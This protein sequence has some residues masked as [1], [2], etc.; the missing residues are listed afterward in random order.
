MSKKGITQEVVE[1]LTTA[2]GREF[3]LYDEDIINS[4]ARSTLFLNTRPIAVVF[5]KE[6]REVVDVVRIANKYSLAIHPIS[7]GKNWGYSDA[8][9]YEEASL[10]IDLHRMDSIIEVNTDLCYAVVEPGVTQKKLFNYLRDHNIPLWMDATGAD[11]DTSII[12]NISER[13]FGYS[14]YG[15]R[16]LSS[17]A[18]EVVLPSGE[19]LSTGFSHYKT[20]KVSHVYKWGVGPSLDGLFTQSN[21]GIITKM[22]IHLRPQPEYFKAMCIGLEN[23]EDIFPFIESL[24]YCKLHGLIDSIVHVSNDV[25]V[26]SSLQRFPGDTNFFPCLD[27]TQKIL[28]KQKYGVVSWSTVIPFYGV[29][30]NI[31]GTISSVKKIVLST[32]RK[33]LIFSLDEKRIHQIDAF[34]LFCNKYKG[35]FFDDI[36]KYF[37]LFQK[38]K[39]LFDILKGKAPASSLQST[40]WRVG[41]NKKLISKNPLDYGV[42]MYW[43]SPVVPME[44]SSLK[45]FFS[46]VNPIFEKFH[47]DNPQT[48]STISDR[49]LCVVLTI[50]FNKDNEEEKRRAKG[51]H[52]EVVSSLTYNGYIVYRSGTETVK[53]ITEN[54]DTFQT[55]LHEIKTTID[56]NNI[57]SVGKYGI[58]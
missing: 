1:D 11:A 49:A 9:A 27:E 32:N 22:T 23:D 28:L 42:G 48:I 34:F 35:V 57:L 52:D 29:K 26:L 12:G 18:Y 19:I 3:F 46:V 40:L 39:V 6:T 2:V 55:F 37:P 33:A 7:T 10:I 50:Y 36:K 54:M 25:R 41:V 13:G 16:F 31:T 21:F 15:D 51:C 4:Y 56:K 58:R 5:P 20:S 14:S 17:C 53:Y 45:H 43:I 30:K 47:F 38:T 44:S 8:R 24:R